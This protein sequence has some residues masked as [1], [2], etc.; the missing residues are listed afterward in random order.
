[1]SFA[2]VPPKTKLGLT[3]FIILLLFDILP[4]HFSVDTNG[5]DK[6]ASGSY[7]KTP[8]FLVQFREISPHAFGTLALQYFHHLGGGVLRCY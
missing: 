6:I 8:V 2:A 7:V 3:D 5:T 4:D 1:M